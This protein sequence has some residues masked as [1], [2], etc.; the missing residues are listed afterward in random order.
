MSVAFSGSADGVLKSWILNTEE[1]ESDKMLK[2]GATLGNAHE[3]AINS[4]HVS[5]NGRNL[6]TGSRDKTAKVKLV[7]RFI[8]AI[9]CYVYEHLF[10]IFNMSLTSLHISS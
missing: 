4:I 7:F 5:A 9:S 10:N 8:L 3:G 2:P 1:R 6:A